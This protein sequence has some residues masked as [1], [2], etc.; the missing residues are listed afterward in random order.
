[1]AN[2]DTYYLMPSLVALFIEAVELAT[3]EEYGLIFAQ[4]RSPVVISKNFKRQ[5]DFQ[6]NCAKDLYVRHLGRCRRDR[7]G[8]LG[9]DKPPLELETTSRL[10]TVKHR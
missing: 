4:S 5:G 9:K 1:M 10:G 8:S 2:P 3:G 7:G 6:L